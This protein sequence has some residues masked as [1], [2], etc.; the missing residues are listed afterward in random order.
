M[1]NVT[2]I[3]SL[4]KSE[5]INPI[6]VKEL[7]KVIGKI[8]IK[9]GLLGTIA[10]NIFVANAK[11]QEQRI[12]PVKLEETKTETVWLYRDRPDVELQDTK[13]ALLILN[14]PVEK[15]DKL[16]E[17]IVMG[18]KVAGVHPILIA[19]LIASESEF[20]E[21]AVSKKHYKGLLQTPTKTGI[22]IADV[23]HGAAILKDKLRITDGKLLPALQLYKGGRNQTALIQARKV[24]ALSESVHQKIKG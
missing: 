5:L 7:V 11:F 19:S 21:T 12:I 16:A 10:Y 18:A 24:I 8:V 2:Y 15:I 13:K 4:T 3:S 1:E 17:A 14:C 23:V 6:L 22:I 20:K 9:V